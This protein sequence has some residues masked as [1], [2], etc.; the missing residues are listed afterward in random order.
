MVSVQPKTAEG[1]AQ[2]ARQEETYMSQLKIFEDAG[3]LV[4]GRGKQE[5]VRGE[6][7]EHGIRR[8][9]KQ[10]LARGR[11]GESGC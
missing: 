6:Q 1:A 2:K 4:E 11:F 9:R 7:L 8:C 10:A 5:R 3:R